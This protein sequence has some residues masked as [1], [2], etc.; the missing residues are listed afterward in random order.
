MKADRAP[1]WT[2]A[3][4]CSRLRC[5]KTAT[6]P[7]CA[8]PWDSLRIGAPKV[9]WH[10]SSPE[11]RRHLPRSRGWRSPG[12]S[13]FT[14]TSMPTTVGTAGNVWRL[15]YR[16]WHTCPVRPSRSN[17]AAARRQRYCDAANAAFTTSHR[18]DDSRRACGR[19]HRTC[20]VG[21]GHHAER[22]VQAR[23][24]NPEYLDVLGG[25]VELHTI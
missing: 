3:P 6:S 10:G 1:T 25:T 21:R 24:G 15:S 7:S 5:A 8:Q 17:P 11:R 22:V 2:P 18:I 20:A 9:H 23:I 4:T 14:S 12:S 13:S 19:P 16:T